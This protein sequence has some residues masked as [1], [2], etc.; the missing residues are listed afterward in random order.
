[1][2]RKGV[3]RREFLSMVSGLGIATA[4]GKL[5]KFFP[6]VDSALAQGGTPINPLLQAPKDL[7]LKPIQGQAASQVISQALKSKDVR[8]LREKLPAFQPAL[9]ESKVTSAVWSKGTQK[10]TV[11]AIP[12]TN[13]QK[14][15]AVLQYITVNGVTQS[16]MVEFTDPSNL[17]KARMY[18]VANQQVNFVDSTSNVQPGGL[19]TASGSNCNKNKMIACLQAWGCSGLALTLC[20]AAFIS[21]PFFIGSCI[22]AWA[23]TLYCGG[24]FSKCWC[25]LCGC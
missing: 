19:S 11:V 18:S 13:P 14:A 25:W 21:C 12:F 8:A 17:T 2:K 7:V 23:C 20:I 9:G 24:A 10:A 5:L 15:E 22:A 16:I 4:I 1:M 3:S 6:E